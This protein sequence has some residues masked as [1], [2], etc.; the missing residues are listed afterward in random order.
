MERKANCFESNIEA[1]LCGPWMP[2]AVLSFFASIFLAL[3]API[4][5]VAVLSVIGFKYTFNKLY[6]RISVVIVVASFFMPIDL[7]VFRSE[8]ASVSVARLYMVGGRSDETLKEQYGLVGRQEN[9][10]YVFRR[11]GTPMTGPKWCLSIGLPII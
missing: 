6:Q 5:F 1:L 9:I 3:N 10:D 2:A 8:K 11:P 7:H 4:F